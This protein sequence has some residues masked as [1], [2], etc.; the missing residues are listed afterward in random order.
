MTSIVDNRPGA[1]DV[2]VVGNLNV[3]LIL[4]GS[5]GLPQWGR[6]I[7][8]SGRKAASSGQAGLLAMALQALGVRTGVIANV[9]NDEAGKRILDDLTAAGVQTEDV[10]VASWATGLSVALVRPDGERAFVTDFGS[11][12]SLDESTVRRHE[13]ALTASKTLCFV[14]VFMLPSLGLEA[15]TA[16]AR[17][18]QER[19]QVTVVDPGWDPEGWPDSTLDAMRELLAHTDV[20]LVN[21]EESKVLTGHS[22]HQRAAAALQEMGAPTVVVKRGG[23]GAHVRRG[24]RVCDVGALPIEVKDTVGAGDTFNAGFLAAE[25]RGGLL[26][27]AMTLGSAVAGIYC[28]RTAS[29]FPSLAE[30]QSRALE[31]SVSERTATDAIST[32]ETRGGAQ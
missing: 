19:G 7:T 29:R 22:D 32:A 9:G 14:G 31:L 25:I 26:A 5:D 21:D 3:D 2:T 8:V 11:L 23:Q 1:Y 27:D 12:A 15:I 10:E 18:A 20:L 6:E 4:Y 13:D 17:E 24:S 30:A 28:S 16:L